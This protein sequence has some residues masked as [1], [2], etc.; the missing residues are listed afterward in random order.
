MNFSEY[1]CLV[2]RNECIITLISRN[3]S[4]RHRE[5]LP[6]SKEQSLGGN[7]HLGVNCTDII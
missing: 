7:S 2:P 5:G 4:K 1:Q 6:E 3:P